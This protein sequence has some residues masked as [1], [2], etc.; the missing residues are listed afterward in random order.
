VHDL[1]IPIFDSIKSPV[2]YLCSKDKLVNTLKNTNFELLLV[3]G[4]GDIINYL[5]E[6]CDTFR[7]DN[8]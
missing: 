2:K 6:I 4:A 5:P 8:K 1:E 3:A 7:C